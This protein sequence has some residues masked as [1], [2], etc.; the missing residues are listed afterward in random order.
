ELN[1]SP[2]RYLTSRVVVASKARKE[3]IVL[4]L[5]KLAS[6]DA[7]NA[8]SQLESKWGPQLTPEERNWVWGV[9]AKQAAQR[10]GNDALDHYAKVN[11]DSDMTDEMLAWKARAALRSVRGTQWPVVLQAINAMTEDTRRDPAWVYWKARA[12]LARGGDDQRAEAQ[13]LLESIASPRG[14][15]EQLA[16]EELG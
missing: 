12:L 9:I 8:A 7:D 6:S 13:R 2:A 16:T 11:R 4:A 3:M 15:Y 1:R 14:F 5:I 10:L